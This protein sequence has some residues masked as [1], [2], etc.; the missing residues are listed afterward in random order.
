MVT[1]TNCDPVPAGAVTVMPVVPF[2]EVTVASALP[3]LT[4]ALGVKSVPVITTEVPPPGGPV[5]GLI[6]LTVGRSR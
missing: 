2:R 4:V 3:N 1:V 5:A 6:E